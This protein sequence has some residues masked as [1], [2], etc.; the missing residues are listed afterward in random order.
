MTNSQGTEWPKDKLKNNPQNSYRITH[1]QIT[2]WPTDKLEND[3][4]MI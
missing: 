2:E 4:Q 3:S 1:K